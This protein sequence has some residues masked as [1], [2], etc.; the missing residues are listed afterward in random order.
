[1]N[2]LIVDSDKNILE[3]LKQ[4]IQD[5]PNFPKEGILFKDITPIF[6]Q[7]KLCRAIT[8]RI[9][10]K[11][12]GID[13]VVGI[14]SRG[15]FWG[16]SVAQELNVPFVPIRKA[17]K[18]PRATLS[19]SYALEYGT[20]IIEV[21]QDAIEPGWNVLIHD[22]LLA[23]GGTALAAAKLVNQLGI[24]AGFSFLVELGFLNGRAGLETFEVEID[25]LVK[26]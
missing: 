13:A 19:E 15:F 9:A 14:E 3:E 12:K 5:V 20:A 21:H 26:Y 2:F 16:M 1:M 24:V 10:S 7:P 4:V 25:A 6:A 22:D 23:T 18:L 11:F 17:G 8:E